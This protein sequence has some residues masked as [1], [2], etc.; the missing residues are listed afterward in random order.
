M[1][2]DKTFSTNANQIYNQNIIFTKIV[3]T[4]L[5]EKL[6]NFT[7]IKLFK[8]SNPDSVWIKKETRS[9]NSYF[10]YFQ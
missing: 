8:I 4:N 3:I 9:K 5:R 7:K 6:R 2:S 10:L 1:V